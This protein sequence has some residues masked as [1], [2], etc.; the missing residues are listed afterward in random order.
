MDRVEYNSCDMNNTELKEL[1]RWEQSAGERMQTRQYNRRQEKILTESVKM[2]RI[3]V[4]G[5]MNT[6]ISFLLL[7]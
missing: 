3:G 2:D 1:N 5:K 4:R 7:V 6:R